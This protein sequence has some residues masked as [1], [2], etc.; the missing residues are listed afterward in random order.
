MLAILWSGLILAT[1]AGAAA[2]RFPGIAMNRA[3]IAL[4]GATALVLTGAISRQQAYAANRHPIHTGKTAKYR[5]CGKRHGRQR[6][7]QP[8][9][10]LTGVLGRTR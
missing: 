8:K 4:V 5:Q 10:R 2:G 7:G 3:T 1:L 6:Q 9:D